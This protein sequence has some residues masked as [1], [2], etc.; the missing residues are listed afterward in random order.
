MSRFSD[1]AKKA[2]DD[3]KRVNANV[4]ANNEEWWKGKR[5]FQI[6]GYREQDGR[7]ESRVIR[8]ES[9]EP[10][11]NLSAYLVIG[12]EDFAG[13]DGLELRPISKPSKT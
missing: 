1:L 4:E 11:S 10:K 5:F 2:L 13:Y 3:E 9:V 8:E 12:L 6:I 7:V